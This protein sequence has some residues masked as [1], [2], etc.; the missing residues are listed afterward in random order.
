MRM[1][2]LS[3]F[4]IAS[5]AGCGQASNDGPTKAAR[6]SVATNATANANP[7][8]DAAAS[9]DVPE[10][11]MQLTPLS[12]DDIALYVQV[13]HA[14]ADRV[15]HRTAADTATLARYKA[16]MQGADSG[17]KNAP[18]STTDVAVMENGTLIEQQMDMLVV[19]ERHIDEKRYN[20]ISS[21]IEDVIPNP[22]MEVAGGATGEGAPA[23]TPQLSGA[24]LALQQKIHT[25]QA[26]D[27]TILVPY[28]SEVQQ[29]LAI[30]RNPR[31]R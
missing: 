10:A 3:M 29:L 15:Q 20:G 31:R 13:M 5:M 28:R 27:T 22:K 16:L 6:T 11:S 18:P 12:K 30:V 7:T 2:F 1:I 9:E 23:G 21:A 26:Q 4:C 14:A 17:G 24:S 19:R 8:S 25:A